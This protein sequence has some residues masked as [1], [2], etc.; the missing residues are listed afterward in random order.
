MCGANGGSS[1][2]NDVRALAVYF[3]RLAALLPAPPRLGRLSDSEG[4]VGAGGGGAE[5]SDP[6]T[7]ADDH[8]QLLRQLASALLRRRSAG[9]S[10]LLPVWPRSHAPAKEDGAAQGGSARFAAGTFATAAT[11]AATA[12]AAVGS[13][14]AAAAADGAEAAHLAAAEAALRARAA[15][16]FLGFSDALMDTMLDGSA[17]VPWPTF[18]F[19][20]T[21]PRGPAALTGGGSGGGAGGGSGAEH[22]VPAAADAAI[23]SGAVSSV[24]PLRDFGSKRT[25]SWPDRILYRPPLALRSAEAQAQPASEAAV[26]VVEGAPTFRWERAYTAV[27]DVISSDHVP[28]TAALLLPL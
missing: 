15:P 5:C 9:G 25:P 23:S 3:D 7:A 8:P 13:D 11:A 21:T 16:L 4:P 2:D 10:W 20:L 12:A 22:I 6:Q 27:H 14:D 17:P 26:A 18:T 28:I 24:R 19:P 1:A